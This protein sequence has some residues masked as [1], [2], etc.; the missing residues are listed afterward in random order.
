V[1]SRRSSSPLQDAGSCAEQIALLR[2]IDDITFETKLGDLGMLSY[3]W[4]S[5]SDLHQFEVLDALEM[6]SVACEKRQP[7]RQSNTGDQTVGH[8][9]RMAGTV[10]FPADICRVPRGSAVERQH[11]ERIKQVADG[12]PPLIFAGTA[13]KLEVAHSRRLELVCADVFRNLTLHRLGAGKEIDENI[14]IRKNHRQLSRSCLAVRRNSSPSFFESEPPSD[15]RALRRFCRSTSPCK[16]NSMASASTAENPFCP[17]RV[18]RASRALR[19]S[20]FISTVVRTSLFYMHVHVPRL[21][22]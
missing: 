6:S 5:V 11:A 13:Q 20:G 9:D 3:L 21:A 7:V 15:S 17:R 12:M 4:R 2:F 10:K 19:C 1:F 14:R 16:K 18:A 22:N 8:S